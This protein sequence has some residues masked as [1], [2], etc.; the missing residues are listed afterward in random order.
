MASIHRDILIHAPATALWDA[1]LDIGALHTRLA[2]GF[3]THC[4]MDGDAARQIRF[5]NGVEARELIVTVDGA[6]R[7]LVWSAAGGRLTH[8]NASAQVF[9]EGGTHCRVAWI[10]D[11][12]PDAMAPAITRMIEAGLLA[13]KTHAEQQAETLA[14]AGAKP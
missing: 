9:D 2:P 13:M 3:V 6:S 10:A 14:A 1:L 11:L 8:H 5:A 4:E 12:L 7:R